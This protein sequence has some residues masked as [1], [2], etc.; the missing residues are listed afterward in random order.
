MRLSVS[1]W[2]G[3]NP[4]PSVYCGIAARKAEIGIGTLELQ[5]CQRVKER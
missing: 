5:M 2:L 1:V 4:E 3:Y